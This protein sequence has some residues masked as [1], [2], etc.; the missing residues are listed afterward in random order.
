MESCGQRQRLDTRQPLLGCAAFGRLGRRLR[1]CPLGCTPTGPAGH[2]LRQGGDC[3]SSV[4]VLYGAAGARQRRRGV[5]TIRGGHPPFWS[6]ELGTPIAKQPICPARGSRSAG[7][8]PLALTDLILIQ[9][10]RENTSIHSPV[11]PETYSSIHRLVNQ[12]I[13]TEIAH[14]PSF[15]KRWRGSRPSRHFTQTL[16]AANLFQKTLIYANQSQL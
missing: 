1:A 12:S 7:R 10:Y 9:T 11:N 5:N 14:L 8:F 2:P 4:S 3:V 13:D 6:V 15:E 16:T